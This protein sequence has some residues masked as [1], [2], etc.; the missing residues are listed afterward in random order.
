[1]PG[2]EARHVLALPIFC[3]QQEGTTTSQLVLE[4]GAVIGVVTIGSNADSSR[5]ALCHE[6]AASAI[7]L[8]REAQAVAEAVV[9]RM[10]A[11]RDSRITS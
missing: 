3:A 5:I 8:I 11:I 6:D 1:L 4:P 7:N 10:L 2:L 9:L